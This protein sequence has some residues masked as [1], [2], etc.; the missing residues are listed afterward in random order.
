MFENKLELA[1]AVMDRV[2]ARAE[3]GGYHAQRFRF[4]SK[5]AS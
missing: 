5:L 3:A 4:P 2:K 1:Y